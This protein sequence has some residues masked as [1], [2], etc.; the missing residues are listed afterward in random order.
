MFD[1]AW[2]VA[3]MSTNA[4]TF[5]WTC[6]YTA[7]K[8]KENLFTSTLPNTETKKPVRRSGPFAKPSGKRSPKVNDESYAWRKEHGLD[9]DR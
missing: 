6:L 9:R 3:L 2:L 4:L 5:T 8:V 7:K 1:V